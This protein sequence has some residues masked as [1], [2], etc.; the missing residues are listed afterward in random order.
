M[1][2]THKSPYAKIWKYVGL[3]KNVSNSLYHIEDLLDALI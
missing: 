1:E 2:E 3:R